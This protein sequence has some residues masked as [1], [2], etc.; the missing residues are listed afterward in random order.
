MGHISHSFDLAIGDLQYWLDSIDICNG[1]IWLNRTKTVH[2]VGDASIIG[3][4][5]FTPHEEVEF[6][7]AMSLDQQ[8]IHLMQ[9]QSLSSVY[10]ETKHARLA[11]QY[12]VQCMGAEMAGGLVVYS[13]DRFPAI[14]DLAKMKGACDIFVEVKALYLYVAQFDV[15]VNFSWLPRTN[16]WLQHADE[17]SRLPGSSELCIRPQ[18]LGPPLAAWGCNW[19]TLGPFAGAASGQHTAFRFYTWHYAPSCLGV[20]GL[21][22]HWA[23]NARLQAS[24]GLV[25]LFPPFSLIGPVLNK[26]QLERVNAI[27]ILP[28]YMRVWVSVLQQLPVVQQR[29]LGFHKGLFSVGSKARSQWL[30]EMPRIPLMAVLIA[31]NARS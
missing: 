24:P 8:G 21:L 16:E 4:A 6:P 1:R 28:K 11:V 13:G 22:Q 7:M 29:D 25:W 20:N 15:Q 14:Q 19:P 18:Q 31:R 3:Y 23:V 10:R 9:S 26:L 27:L 2:V 5:A 30:Q 12:V 17:L